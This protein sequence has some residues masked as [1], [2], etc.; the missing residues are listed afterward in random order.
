MAKFKRSKSNLEIDG[1]DLK[2]IVT[3]LDWNISTDKERIELVKKLLLNLDYA[4]VEILNDYLI[5]LMSQESGGE[6]YVNVNLIKTSQ[7]GEDNTI[8]RTLDTF[9]NYIVYSPN[10]DR[11]NKAVKYNF[12]TEDGMTKSLKNRRDFREIKDLEQNN[13]EIIDFIKD[14][15]TNYKKAKSLAKVPKGISKLH[16]YEL[17]LPFEESLD[18]F[19]KKI[20]NLNKIVKQEESLDCYD[21]VKINSLKKEISKLKKA[22][23]ELRSDYKDSYE[24]LQKPIRFKAPLPDSTR[25][26]YDMFDF[27][28]KEHVFALL[29]FD[30]DREYVNDTLDDVVIKCR[31]YIKRC[32]FDDFKT[33]LLDM[34]SDGKDKV[35][36]AKE[37]KTTHQNIHCHIEKIVDDIIKQYK[38]DEED[39][40]YTYFEVGEY[41]KCSICGE[42][43]LVSRFS[44]KASNKDGRKNNC[45]VCESINNK[46]YNKK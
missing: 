28:N 5:K 39:N 20:D 24:Y 2:K 3:N 4:D 12:Y 9:A 46:K 34:I 44:V 33:E 37:L 16:G 6:A 31:D 15:N 38:Y 32:E 17:L 30:L 19:H 45:K 13:E 7:L 40:Y 23:M 27:S 1:E 43:K 42:I 36:I 10:L 18:W 29:H 22:Q 11:M 25:I 41:K 26:D 35:V 21:A 8:F 14:K